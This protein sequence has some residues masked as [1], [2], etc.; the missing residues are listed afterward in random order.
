M[1]PDAPRK[2]RDVSAKLEEW[3]A[4]VEALEKHGPAYEL[5]LPFRVTALRKIMVHA[6]DWFVQNRFWSTPVCLTQETYQ[7]LYTKCEDWGE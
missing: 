6:E 4:L 3:R 7:K 1:N 2:L 5:G